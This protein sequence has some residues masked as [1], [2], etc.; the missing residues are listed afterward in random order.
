MAT[1]Q[2]NTGF[3][4]LSTQHNVYGPGL[5]KADFNSRDSF[6][7]LLAFMEHLSEFV[8]LVLER[9]F[10]AFG[11]LESAFRGRCGDLKSV[12]RHT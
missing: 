5:G 8:C 2:D 6:D 11:F 1:L 3:V 10:I 7:V 9:P 12:A 4:V